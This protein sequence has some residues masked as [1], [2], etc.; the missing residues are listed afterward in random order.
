MSEFSDQSDAR[1]LEM[2][3]QTALSSG[4]NFQN[5]LRR[6]ES[7]ETTLPA[8]VITARVTGED[9]SVRYSNRYAQTLE[10]R[11]SA[12]VSAAQ[13]DSARAL[14]TF[15]RRI[16]DTI[17]AASGITGWNYLRIEYQG[18]EVAFDGVKREHT[19]IWTVTAHAA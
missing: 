3:F 2:T 16:K 8:A 1:K 4:L 15:Q 10:L 17:E 9:M 12:Q 19:H 11:A 13:P 14:E 18:D 6:N 5:V 7:T